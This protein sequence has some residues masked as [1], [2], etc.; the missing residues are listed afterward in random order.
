MGG[1]EGLIDTAVKTSETGYIQRRL[2]KAME[3]MMVKYDG[4]VRNAGGEVLQ[5]L[6][7]EDGMDATS[8]QEPSSRT[9]AAAQ[10]EVQHAF[11][12]TSTTPTTAGAHVRA[13]DGK[14][15]RSARR[16]RVGDAVRGRRRCAVMSTEGPERAAREPQASSGTL[17][18]QGGLVKDVSARAAASARSTSRPWTLISRAFVAERAGGSSST[19]QDRLVARGAAQRHDLFFAL[20]RSTLSAKR[21]MREFKLSSQAFN[22]VSARSRSASRWRWRPAGRGIGTVAAQSIGEPARR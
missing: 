19:G 11:T 1:R 16:R 6:Y 7:G 12:S 2:V 21:V 9:S 17:Q 4:T 20:V 18:G 8:R 22:W 10:R 5:F 14:P 3:D 13:G 15:W